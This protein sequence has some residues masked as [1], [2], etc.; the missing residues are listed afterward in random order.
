MGNIVTVFAYD[1][2][3][4]ALKELQTI[5]TLPAGFKGAST[6]AEIAVDREGR[7]V[8]CS[9][10]GHESIAVYAIDPAKGTLTSV[11]IVPS[12]GKEPRN[13]QLDPTGHF[14]LAAN[15]NS[16]NIA[17]YRVDQKTGKLTA[18]G[19]SLDIQAPV[20]LKFVQMQ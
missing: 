6:T 17:V 11:E 15:Q 7:F 4:G 1:P 3:A 12:G 18:T 9:N 8:Y 5:T 10:R 13:F 16:N 2:A 19:Q 20:C 14:L